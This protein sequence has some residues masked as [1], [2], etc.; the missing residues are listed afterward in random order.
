M[1]PIELQ[2]WLILTRLIL[3]GFLAEKAVCCGRVTD[4]EGITVSAGAPVHSG[5]GNVAQLAHGR[6]ET[7]FVNWNVRSDHSC[8]PRN[9]RQYCMQ[10]LTHHEYALELSRPGAW[11]RQ[12][13]P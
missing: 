9:G 12:A 8:Q 1:G 5:P 2:G 3:Q 4:D 10:T 13:R 7:R 11:F 6:L